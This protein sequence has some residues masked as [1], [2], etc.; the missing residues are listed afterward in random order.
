MQRLSNKIMKIERSNDEHMYVIGHDD[1]RHEAAS[2]AIKYDDAMVSLR[3]AIEDMLSGW[4]YI[5]E[6]HGDLYGVG[7]DRAQEKAESA[8][9]IV[10]QIDSQKTK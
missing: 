3:D 8:L 6:Q 2:M 1:A 4:K 7:W 10:R 9:E 5:R